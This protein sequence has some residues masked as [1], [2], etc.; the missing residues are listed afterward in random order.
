[1]SRDEQQSMDELR[2]AAGEYRF[3]VAPPLAAAAETAAER[4]D[5]QLFN[6]MASMLALSWMVEAL[7]GRY[8]E[9]VPAEQRTSTEQALDAAPLG[10][11]ALVFTESDLDEDTVGECLGALRQAGRMLQADGVDRAGREALDEAWAA[12]RD[13]QHEQAIEQLRECTRRMTDA[14]D[15]W[16]AA[17]GAD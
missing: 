11:C 14:I 13:E 10:A 15:A 9:M 4:G 16:E 7:V 12:L 1:M 5:P 8:R 3:V 17:R 6:D 2:L